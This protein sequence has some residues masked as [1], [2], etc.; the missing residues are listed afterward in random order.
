LAEVVIKNDY[1]IPYKCKCND[2]LHVAPIGEFIN[3]VPKDTLIEKSKNRICDI[4][5][6]IIVPKKY[7]KKIVEHLIKDGKQTVKVVGEVIL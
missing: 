5:E 6:S 1:S 4:C 2:K 3:E 7:I